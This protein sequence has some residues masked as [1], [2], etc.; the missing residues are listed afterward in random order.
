MRLAR[1][2]GAFSWTD[3]NVQNRRA[4][5]MSHFMSARRDK[6]R[7]T[8]NT[9]LLIPDLLIPNLLIPNLLFPNSLLLMPFSLLF[10]LC[11]LGLLWRSNRFHRAQRVGVPAAGLVGKD[12]A[13][14]L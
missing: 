3:A 2:L 5:F 9:D 1:I 13:H 8:P 6:S 14:H 4:T 12:S 7:T 10:R 11:R